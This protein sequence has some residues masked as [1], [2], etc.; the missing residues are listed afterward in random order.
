MAVRL[1]ELMGLSDDCETILSCFELIRLRSTLLC[2]ATLAA[3]MTEDVRSS[4]LS[5]RIE[6]IE[7]ALLKSRVYRIGKSFL[8]IFVES[9]PLSSR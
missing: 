5:L 6:N 7:S 1:C 4:V 8:F 3:R 9:R 2:E